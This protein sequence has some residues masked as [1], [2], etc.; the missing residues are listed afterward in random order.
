MFQATVN[1]LFNSI[2]THIC[3]VSHT[4]V[5]QGSA[6]NAAKDQD[7]QKPVLLPNMAGIPTSLIK[8]MELCLF[9]YNVIFRTY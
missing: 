1:Y 3:N 9:L 4:P 8:M 7:G 5:V 6:M 2:E